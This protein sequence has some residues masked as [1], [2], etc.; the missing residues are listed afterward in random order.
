MTTTLYER[1]RLGTSNGEETDYKETFDEFVKSLMSANLLP[2]YDATLCRSLLIRWE[3]N[4]NRR[5]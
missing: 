1:T 3:A 2:E 5:R 4:K